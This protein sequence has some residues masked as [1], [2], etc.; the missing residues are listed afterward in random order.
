MSA[1]SKGDKIETAWN[2]DE[3]HSLATRM[4]GEFFRISERRRIRHNPDT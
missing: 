4:A 2:G 1:E 3:L